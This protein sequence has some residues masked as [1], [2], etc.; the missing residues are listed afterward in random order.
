MYKSSQDA[1]KVAPGGYVMTFH[2]FIIV[3]EGMEINNYLTQEARQKTHKSI[4]E[5]Q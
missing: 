3:Q 1:T 5:P 4:E 2:A